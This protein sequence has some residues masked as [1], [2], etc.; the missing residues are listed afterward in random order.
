MKV[1][2]CHNFYQRPG[3]EDQV[4]ADE[5]ALLEQRGHQVIRY[6]VHNDDIEGAGRL[7]LIGRTIWNRS[8]HAEIA[9]LVRREKAQVVHF[10]NTFPLM[11][12]AAYYAARANG[13]AVVQTLHNYRLFCPAGVLYRDGKVC[14]DCLGKSFPWPGV[15]RGCYRGSVAATAVAGG[16]L[17]IHRA[18]GSFNNGVD[19]YVAL[20]EFA[21]DKCIEGGLPAAR[22]VVKPNFVSP[23][24]TPGK[25]DGGYAA[26]VGRLEAEKGVETLIAAWR[27]H[28]KG[29]R[30]K[31][32]GHG[33]LA[34]D[35]QRAVAECED[36]E[37]LGRLPQKEVHEA[38]GRASF[39]VIP[40]QWYEGFPKTLLEA[41]AKGT[42]ALASKI[43]SLAELVE[44]GK[45]GLHFEPGNPDDLAAKARLMLSDPL[46]LACMRQNAR[47]EY[48]TKYT[49]DQNYQQLR[50]VYE[51][52]L[53]NFNGNP[54]RRTI[55]LDVMTPN[56][57]ASA[58]PVRRPAI[59]L[60]STRSHAV[61][62]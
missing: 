31:I 19:T 61:G 8:V 16:M 46:G 54:R 33:P 41:Y 35:V 38:I 36:I 3:G 55:P 42:P 27:R 20:S 17:S 29:V 39:L 49:P 9:D 53:A 40:S 51:H 60:S 56:E 28:M 2:V 24:P 26:F 44:D 48:E 59:G 58:H 10:H 18:I 1:I 32:V 11:S 7:A 5:T 30:L 52:A 25:G 13:A 37:W 23:D 45:T 34:G 12:P 47:R 62:G 4:F 21:R 15:A 22:V 6:T 14:E 43:G 57:R 50:D